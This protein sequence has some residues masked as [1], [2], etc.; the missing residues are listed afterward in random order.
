MLPLIVIGATDRVKEILTPYAEVGHI[1]YHPT[2]EAAHRAL[3]DGMPVVQPN[4]PET[5][6]AYSGADMLND[7][8]LVHVAYGPK[9]F[10][11]LCTGLAGTG[12]LLNTMLPHAG[13]TLM[14]GLDVHDPKLVIRAIEGHPVEEPEQTMIWQAGINAKA[15]LVL[16]LESTD[17][18]NKLVRYLEWK[19]AEVTP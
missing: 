13:H 2:A 5:L 10:G 19:S 15:D 7:Q 14:F 16:D 1:S 11:P 8:W 17:A 12:A 9:A 18:V 6:V 4:P 3:L